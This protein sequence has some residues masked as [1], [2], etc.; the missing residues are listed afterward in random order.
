MLE[1]L[2]ASEGNPDLVQISGGEPSLHPQIMDILRLAKS[3]PIRHVMLNTNGIRIA[4]DKAFV[5]ELATLKPGF[6][7]YLQFDSLR[8]EALENLRGADLRKVREKA[9]A[10]LEAAGISTTLVCVVK[11]GV[12]DDEAG[13]IVR[14]ALSYKC[15]RGITFH[16]APDAG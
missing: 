9:L 2:V 8:R 14:H 11:K 4:T 3:K 1:T 10:N 5:T 7:V 12:N 6:E 16:P 13:A 15:V